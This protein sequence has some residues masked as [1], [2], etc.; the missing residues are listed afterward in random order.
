MGTRIIQYTTTPAH[1]EENHRL[2]ERVF[3]ELHTL[4]L[5][6]LDSRCYR[7]AD[8]L[9]FIHVVSVNGADDPLA[10]VASFAEFQRGLADRCAGPVMVSPA[11]VEGIY[12][13]V[14]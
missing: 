11:G 8:G 6:G 1:A 12:S 5:P 2:V 13:S 7:L 9:T 4:G 10:H 3:T 14:S